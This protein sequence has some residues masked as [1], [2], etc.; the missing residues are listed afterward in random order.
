MINTKFIHLLLSVLLILTMGACAN[1]AT[2]DRHETFNIDNIKS[3][4][5]RNSEGGGDEL[6][7]IMEKK[8]ISMNYTV[9]S[10]DEISPT[11]DAIITYRD[12][13]MWDLTMYMIELTVT[14]R[15]K[16]S[17]FPLATGNSMHTS[18]TRKS[19]EEMVDEV[20]TNLFT[21]VEK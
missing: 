19:E 12:K 5:I 10:G 13:W 14:V 21:K 3:L 11:A 9:T 18:L 20:L 1:R 8:L 6:I 4:H 17:D 2:V 7:P 16:N 15:D